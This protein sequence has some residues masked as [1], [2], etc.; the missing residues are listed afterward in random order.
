MATLELMQADLRARPRRW[1]VTGVAGFIASN[2]AQW[3]LDGDQHVV[4]LD[5]FA[6]GKHANLD[7]VRG[8]VGPARW[9]RFRFI[10][11]DVAAPD[12]CRQAVNGADVVL[13]QAALGSVPRSIEEPLAS[14][15][16]NVTGHLALLEAARRAGVRR[17]VY[18]SSSSVYGDSPTLPKLEE[19]LGRP[20]SPY[21]V[22]KQAD[23][24]Y[25]TVYGRLHGMETV[26]LRYFNVFGPRQDPEGA[27][28]AVI[29]KW[30]AAMLRGDEVQING[31]G[32]I[33][34]DF[35]HVSNVVQANVLAATI[36]R[37]EA[38]NQVYNIA[39][40]RRTTLDEL[41]I[42]LRDRLAA[43]HPR[44]A[45][46]R[47]TYGPFRPGDVMHSLADIA[48]A[49]RLLGYEPTHSIERGLDESLDWYER[50]LK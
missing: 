14:N 29:P 11:G 41:F 46:S 3:L 34:R 24:L 47:P 21:A 40:G 6:T 5:N 26:G 28:A 23:E 17:F 37:P 50:N 1:L 20:L 31:T 19:D 36:E 48:K 7:E 13:H 15:A 35:C 2:L 42:L 45:L 39:L 44:L 43:R 16:A 49:C 18:A 12:V 22:T 9:A 10:E 38:L 32:D 4:G 33:S 25:A 30:I 27:Y 8:L